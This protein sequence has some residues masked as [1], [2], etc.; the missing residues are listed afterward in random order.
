VDDQ[1]LA[2]IFKKPASN[3]QPKQVT[4]AWSGR[5]SHEKRMMEFLRAIAAAKLPA[6]V[7]VFG[8]GPLLKKAQAF[9]AKNGLKETVVLVG[10]VSHDQML[11]ELSSADAL[12]Q[13]SIGFETQGMTV[14]EAGVVGTPSI[15]CDSNIANE[16]PANSYWL[17]PDDTVGALAGVLRMAY[18]QIIEGSGKSID[19]RQELYQSHLVA[20]SVSVYQEAIAKHFG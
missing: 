12:I 2:G 14:Y 4:F 16:L 7:K 18:K 3:H 11:Q 19:L 9:I 13:T 15:L 1:N 5:F 8:G 20:K 17:V 6:K 10:R